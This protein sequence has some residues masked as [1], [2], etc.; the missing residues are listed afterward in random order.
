[1]RIVPVAASVIV[2]YL[3][4]AGVLKAQADAAAEREKGFVLEGT[5]QG[6]A[7]ALGTIT[8]LDTRAGYK[9]SRHLELNA[10][11]PFYF[12]RASS[13]AAAQGATSGKGIGNAY[14]SLRLS[15]RNAAATFVSSVTGKAPTGD[16]S[17]GFSTGRV[18]VDWSNYLGFHAG[19]VTPFALLGL[20]NSISDTRFFTR[21]FASLGKAAGFEGGAHVEMWRIAGIGAS[22]YADVPFGRQKVYSKLV[23]GGQAT[24]QGRGIGRGRGRR[25][26]VFE[27]QSVA[28]GGSELLRD[29]GGSVWLDISPTRYADFEIGFSRSVKYDLNSLFFSIGLNLGEWI[30]SRQQPVSALPH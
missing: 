6:N 18:T 10:G 4:G 13:D 8:K 11:I 17:R 12:V 29:H 7:N 3:C 25:V 16:A 26:G 21:P 28:I 15:A 23:T 27:T 20:S 19:R 22:A 30:R 5:F 14:L 2:S 9:F 1:M 24:P